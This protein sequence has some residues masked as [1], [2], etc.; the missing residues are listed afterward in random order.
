[1]KKRL[2]QAII[3]DLDGTLIDSSHDIISSVNLTLEHFGFKKIEYETGFH[4]IGDGIRMLVKRVLAYIQSGKP[5]A[6][7]DGTL[8][9][10]ADEIFRKMYREH[11]LDTTVPYPFVAETLEHL[12]EYPLAVIS[13]KAF[14]YTQAILKHFGMDSYFQLILGGDSLP[15]KKPHPQPLLHAAGQFHIESQHCLMVGDSEKDITAAK[16]AGMPVCAVTYGL[17]SKVTLR[18]QNP[19]YLIDHMTDLL[20]IVT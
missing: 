6:D 19:D 5:D 13:N 18:A 7:V 1:M 11:M 4:F 12:A 17:S 10:R 20:T 15:Q 3:F 16:N 8:L 14:V 2:Y 9:D